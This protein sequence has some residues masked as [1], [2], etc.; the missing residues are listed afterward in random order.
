[1][2][3]GS[4]TRIAP[5][6]TPALPVDR[7]PSHWCTS[8][9]KRAFD[10]VGACLGVAV[11]SPLMLI[12]AA[13]VACSSPGAV[14][15]RQ[16]RVGQDGRIFSLAKFRT[17]RDGSAESGPGI[18]QA[19]DCRVTA[20]GQIL[21]KW[22]IDE[23]PQLFNVVAGDMSMVGP[24][25]DLPEFIACLPARLR[26][27]LLLKPGVTGA[28]TLE[29]RHEETT[30]AAVPRA[31]LIHHYTDVLLARKAEADLD[32][33]HRATFGSDFVLLIRTLAAIFR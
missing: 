30:L 14:L 22:K 27:L 32:Y 33:A 13:A 8:R 7:M 29:F 4:V 20:V 1:M 24:R 6:A 31:Q 18:T 17:M 2:G 26:P 9:G 25:P 5:A 16:Q 21:R 3:R 28:A 15:F 23:L 19:G 11:T 10:F 12:A